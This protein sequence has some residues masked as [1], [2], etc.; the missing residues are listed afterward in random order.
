MTLV[1]DIFAGAGGWDEGLRQV[2]YT[3]QLA[4]FD[5]DPWACRTAVA[6]GHQRILADVATYPL[7]HLAGRVT[8]LV[9]SPPC[10]A[11][12]PAGSM[13]GYHGP[14]GN[15]IHE[16]L[17]WTLGLQPAWTAWECAATR[18]VRARFD[19]DAVTLRRHGY[20]VWTGAVNAAEFGVPADRR[21]Q[22]LVARRGGP[23]LVPAA[24]VAARRSMAD[25]LGW[26]GAV[27]I[28]NYGTNGD[29]GRRGRR[30][31]SMPAFTVTGKCGRNRWKWPDGSSRNVTVEE[32]GILQT[33]RG[34]YPWQGG[35]IQRQ[36]QVGDA[37]PP[38]MA[39]AL[40]RPLI[41]TSEVRVA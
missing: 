23:I 12:T 8:G 18:A 10:K 3:G 33:F 5:I 16:P 6:A 39:A 32:A 30:D 19:A 31:M 38:L 28:S 7:G 34:D 24:G 20:G 22:I 36:Q 13:L 9:A 37:V 21:R 15:L 11:W 26:S 4:G 40:L 1:L 41:A 35:S 27:L 29:P 14:G 17:R 2:G 25:A